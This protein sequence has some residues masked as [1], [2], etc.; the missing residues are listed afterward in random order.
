MKWGRKGRKEAGRE[1]ESQGGR[2]GAREGEGV[3]RGQRATDGR[4]PAKEVG[5]ATGP[6]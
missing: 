4:E 1:G 5:D 3:E 6:K 2:K